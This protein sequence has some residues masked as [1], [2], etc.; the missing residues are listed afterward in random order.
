MRGA[1][2]RSRFS[3]SSQSRRDEKGRRP[4]LK[5]KKRHV[6]SM[7]RLPTKCLAT[8]CWDF[9]VVKTIALQP[10]PLLDFSSL[11]AANRRSYQQVINNRLWMVWGQFQASDVI[12][13]TGVRP[14]ISAPIV[15]SADANDVAHVH[16]SGHQLFRAQ[17]RCV[18]PPDKNRRRRGSPSH[19]AERP[20][21]RVGLEVSGRAE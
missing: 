14:P 21:G 6:E 7:T 13:Q 1:K 18:A 8:A 9:I 4:V 10:A 12:A 16:V 20:A 11:Q 15:A 3:A 5:L 17:L 19:M 2:R